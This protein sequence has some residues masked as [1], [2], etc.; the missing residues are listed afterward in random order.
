MVKVNLVNIYSDGSGAPAVVQCDGYIFA[1]DYLGHVTCNCLTQSRPPNRVINKA[2]SLYYS[3][4]CKRAELEWFL[5]N[6]KLYRA[7]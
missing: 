1:C 6:H 4:L 5:Q 7:E 3:A 2:K